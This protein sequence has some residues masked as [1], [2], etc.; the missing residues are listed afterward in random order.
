MLDVTKIEDLEAQDSI[1]VDEISYKGKEYLKVIKILDV[2]IEYI[3]YE[4]HGEEIRKVD[5]E[6]VIS[7]FKKMYEIHQNKIYQGDK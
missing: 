2:G 4:I 5:D 6:N 7:Y 1:L 3:Y